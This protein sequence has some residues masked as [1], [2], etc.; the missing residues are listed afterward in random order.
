[1]PAPRLTARPRPGFGP[2]RPADGTGQKARQRSFP[3][4]LLLR[5]IAGRPSPVTPNAPSGEQG[6]LGRTPCWIDGW[7]GDRGADG[8]VGRFVVGRAAGV[9]SPVAFGGGVGDGLA[10][11]DGVPGS[12]VPA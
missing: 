6:A 7:V 8:V 10:D 5:Q 4:E 9:L 1:M 11:G 2:G 12:V 3:S